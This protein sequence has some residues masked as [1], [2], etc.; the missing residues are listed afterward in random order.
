M[1]PFRNTWPYETVRNDVYVSECPY[2]SAENVLIP[3]RKQDLHFIH[4]GRKK[5]LVFPC[6]HNK[7]MLIDVDPDYLLADQPLRKKQ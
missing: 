3:L 6:C 1:I 7:T 2:C 4:E 5:L